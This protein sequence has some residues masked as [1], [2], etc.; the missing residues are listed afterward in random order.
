MSVKNRNSVVE[1]GLVFYVDASNPNSY[2]GSGTTWTDM[3]SS[4]IGTLYNGPS[5]DSANGGSIDFDGSN[6]RTDVPA[7]SSFKPSGSITL[8]VWAK[9]QSGSTSIGIIGALGSSGN[10]GYFMGC[11]TTQFRFSI[12]SNSTTLVNAT[13]SHTDTTSAPFMLTGVYSASTHLKLYK[14]T[15]EIASNTSSIPATQYIGDKPLQ[16]GNRGDSYSKSFWNGN[17]YC[18]MIY[19]KAL[20]ADEVTQNYNALK[21]RFT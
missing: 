9:G 1:D 3:V 4:N 16:I 7:D 19:N 2:P 10:R 12:A 17:V 21:N 11:N 6:D 13:A 5:F 18:A 8:L 20:S 15:S 14:D